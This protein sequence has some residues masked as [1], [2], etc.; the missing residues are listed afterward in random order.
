MLDSNTNKQQLIAGLDSI[1]QHVAELEKLVSKDGDTEQS[2]S[3]LLLSSPAATYVVKG[4]LF[5]YVSPQ[6]RQ[7]TGYSENELIDTDPLNLVLPEDR[8]T[9][10]ENMTRILKGEKSLGYQFR[11]LTKNGEIRW[12]AETLSPILYEGKRAVIANLVDITEQ[13]Q[14]EAAVKSDEEKYRDLCENANDMIQCLTPE[15]SLIYVNR[16]WRE[17]LGYKEEEISRLSMYDIVHPHYIHYCMELIQRTRCGEK[18]NGAEVVFINNEGKTVTVEV[19]MNCRFQDGKPIYIRGILHDVT[20]RKLAEEE[21]KTLLMEV[22]DINHK[23]EQSNRELEEFA[24]V[25]S[26]DLQEPIRKI[27]SFG[28]LLQDSLEDKLDEDQR[29]NLSFMIDGANRMQLMIDDLL[30]YSRITTKAKPFQQVYPNEVVENLKKFEL[31]T[32]LDET[33]GTIQVPQP[34]LCVQCDESQMHQLLQ[35]LISNG[36]KFHRDG[37]PPLIT[38][39]SHPVQNNMVQFDVHDN[40]IGIDDEYHNQIFIMFKR[41]HSRNSYKGTGIGLAICKKIVSRHGGDIG[42]K[43]TPGKGSTFWFTLPRFGS[44]TETGDKG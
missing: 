23:L 43:S 41:L 12:G 31:A 2:L 3:N 38:I 32:M 1:Q 6:L 29:E 19:S 20:E 39:Y 36:L 26:H 15:G 24:Y 17:T 42:V 10:K 33:K 34:L 22:E 18:T 30:A 4:G 28:A 16:V 27:S 35:N 14:E 9:G 8:G 5:K 37:V 11:F 25:A 21:T 44:S 13:K 7:I 40:G